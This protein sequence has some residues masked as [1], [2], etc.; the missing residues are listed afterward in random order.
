MQRSGGSQVFLRYDAQWAAQT[1]AV[2]SRLHPRHWPYR[3]GLQTLAPYTGELYLWANLST[4]PLLFIV[5]KTIVISDDCGLLEMSFDVFSSYLHLSGFHI[6]N[7][8]AS[9]VFLALALL[10]MLPMIF[11]LVNIYRKCIF[12]VILRRHSSHVHKRGLPQL[13][14][15]SS[16]GERFQYASD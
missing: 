13:L 7:T 3:Q 4:I 1:D 11:I 9:P 12:A 8:V 2:W 15:Y 5:L 6:M 10:S 16:L 14:P